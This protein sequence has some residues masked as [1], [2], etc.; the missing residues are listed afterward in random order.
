MAI[1]VS[2][3]RLGNSKGFRIPQSILKSLNADN[4]GDEFSLSVED[5]KIILEKQKEPDVIDELFK[6]FDPDEY[7]KNNDTPEMVDWG[8]SQGREMF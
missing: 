2:V 7:Y 1:T 4:I 3:S 6:G 5:N 8:K